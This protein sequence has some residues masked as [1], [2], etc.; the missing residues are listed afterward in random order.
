M[1]GTAGLL[2]GGRYRLVAPIG[3][4]GMGRVWRGHDDVLDRDVAVKE[5]LLPP[6]IPDVT[7]DQL[8]A[9]TQREARATARLQ[10][11]G[12]VTV[13]DVTEHGGTPWIV[14]ELVRGRSLAAELAEHG[15][16][17]WQRAAVL[18]ADLAEA[19]AH[20]HAAGVVHR[21]LKPDNV[22]VG[23][24]RAVVTDF[25]IA[26][27]LDD[28]MQLTS[29]HTVIGT[30][31]YMAPEQLEGRQ[32]EGAADMW[33][34]GATLFAVVEGRPPFDGPTLTAVITAV[35]TGTP[36]DAPHAGPLA[37][38]LPTLL[39]KD[40]RQRPDAPTTAQRLRDVP[41]PR[42]QRP[43]A[44]TIV[45]PR[46]HDA[47]T[48]S[49][50][51]TP[52]TAPPPVADA[53]SGQPVAPRRPSRRT[54]LIGGGAAALAGAAGGA[55][56]WSRGGDGYED[57]SLFRLT[58]Y[59]SAVNTV[60]F[61]PDGRTLAGGGGMAKFEDPATGDT[62]VRLWNL[63][64]RGLAATLPEQTEKMLRSVVFSPDG[65]TL[66]GVD[67]GRTVRLWDV[68]AGTVDPTR[69]PGSNRY[70][71][72]CSLA[73]SPS[74]AFLA[75]A[76]GYG[77]R[78][79]DTAG[80][81]DAGM[82]YG[83]DAYDNSLYTLAF[84]PDGRLLATGGAAEAV[85]IWNFASRT[86][87]ATLTGHDTTAVSEVAFSPDGRILATA[88]H[89]VTLW[90]VATR[91]PLGVLKHK[92]AE[93]LAFSPNGRTLA[94][95]GNDNDIRLWDVARRTRVA[96]LTGHTDRVKSIAFSPD[97]TTL[98]SGGDDRTI[99]IWRAPA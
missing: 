80:Y 91:S 85:R 1:T 40:P 25:G 65:R 61:S 13:F 78:L 22:L 60:A 92:Y 11:P 29:T 72:T 62:V 93:S 53:G 81:A 33:A 20:A 41:P 47:P 49:A 94:T 18:G 63:T 50:A 79:W 46:I 32:A 48:R 16:W 52:P 77:V 42:E 99:R 96:T 35:L 90:D 97:G 69:S 98:A 7:R 19:L 38:V 68:R 31:H 4:G 15:P 67:Y 75:G 44:V 73:Y 10:H 3:Q 66:A 88:A 54:L 12:I 56:A 58:G 76:D 6:G 8:I 64:D 84:S 70:D 51:G 26:R 89:A 2:V 34:L 74:G 59:G 5:I 55:F 57:K 95:A 39:A 43:P 45:N 86:I 21:D 23:E 87:A 24:H 30:P 71:N 17:P 83:H 14:M 36:P 28:V 9:R 82:M 27:I 37:A